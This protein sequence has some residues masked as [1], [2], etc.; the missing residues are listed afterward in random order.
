MNIFKADLVG[1][2]GGGSVRYA[3]ELQLLFPNNAKFYDEIECLVQGLLS[4]FKHD[5]CDSLILANIG[6]G[7]SFI[8]IDCKTGE[9]N[10]IGG[11]N[12]GGGV[13]RGLCQWREI[14]F[15][16]PS[17]SPSAGSHAKVDTLVSDIY[18]SDY[19]SAKLIGDCVAGSLGKLS[20]ESSTADAIDGVLFML[21]SNMAHLLSLYAS[22]QGVKEIV[23]S[24]SLSTIKG[25]QCAFEESMKYY[26]VNASLSFKFHQKSAHLGCLGIIH[27][28]SQEN[29]KKRGVK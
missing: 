14:E 13:I 27:Q 10:R 21:A 4:E 28:L 16:S 15:P 22:I 25:F 1:L 29:P 19:G 7:A 23:L 6:T 17:P 20:F 2:S 9:F 18:G 26:D 5:A 12:L 11:T 8:K 3:K 24:G